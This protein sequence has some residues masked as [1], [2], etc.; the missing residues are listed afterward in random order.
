MDLPVRIRENALPTVRSRLGGAQLRALDAVFDG[1]ADEVC[2]ALA[3][4][5]EQHIHG[6]C[7][8]GNILIADGDV[9]GFIDLDHLP[10]APRVYDLFYLPPDRLKWRIDEPG[11]PEAMLP[12]FPHLI[13]GYEREQTLTPLTPRERAALWPGMLATQLFF[14]QAFAEQGNQ[15][16]VDRNLC[17]LAWIHTH[18]DDIRQVLEGPPHRPS[19][20]AAQERRAP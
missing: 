8:G 11:A 20:P 18:R 15:E 2:A 7:H 5:P 3:D 14:I 17:A 12:L 13:A 9:S 16:H 19:P 6:D 10:L 1:L 4:L